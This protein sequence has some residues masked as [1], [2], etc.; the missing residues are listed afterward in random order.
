[1]DYKTLLLW[2][3]AP[4]AVVALVLVLSLATSSKAKDFC[5]SIEV[6]EPIRRATRRAKNG[7]F[8]VTGHDVEHHDRG[9]V[10]IDSGQGLDWGKGSSWTAA[11][12]VSYSRETWKVTEVVFLGM[13]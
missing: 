10:Y 9:S 7:G 4:L 11:C 5:D 3:G 12:L 13:N 1:M 2:F 8:D 6:G